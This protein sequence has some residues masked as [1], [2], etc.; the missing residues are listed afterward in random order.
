MV[1]GP[2]V[3]HVLKARLDVGVVK[4]E[5]HIDRRRLVRPVRAE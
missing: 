1:V 2:T 4:S 3:L 5:E